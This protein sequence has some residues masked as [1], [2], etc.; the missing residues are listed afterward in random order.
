V[1]NNHKPQKIKGN[2][3]GKSIVSIEQFDKKDI[4]LL[5]L[6]AMAMRKLVEV[7]GGNNLLSGKILANLFYEPST[8]TS[9]S[10]EAAMKRLGGDVIQ[11]NNVNYSSVA[12]GESVTDTVRTL[13]QYSDLTV[14]RHNQ[15]GSVALAASVAG[16][17]IINAGDGVGEHP[18]QAL[19]DL[20]TIQQ[21]VGRLQGLTVVMVGDLLN[22]RTV[23]S[24]AKLLAL[25]KVNLKFVSPKE[26]K[27][28]PEYT[29][30]LVKN[31]CSHS[32]FSSIEAA[33]PG[34]DVL[35]MT[36]VQKERFSSL[37]EYERL[38]HAYILDA[39]MLKN[40][41]KAL[42]IMH[43]LP[44]VGEIKEEV[45]KDP[46]AKYFEQMKYGMYVRMALLALVLN[47]SMLNGWSKT[48]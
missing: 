14:I 34:A 33:L 18:T 5:F 12:K 47:K 29:N 30:Y 28:P 23:H 37:D 21:T 19:L 22:G 48:A 36:R 13:E 26:L 15:E 35:Y 24:L 16:N 38:K 45:D 6:E 39:K 8:R 41:P 3:A 17:P 2:F 31:G 20:F 40:V 4:E 11:I 43:P 27:M 9:S 32:E 25:Y 1:Q 7:N 42:S 44:R 46:R 10:F